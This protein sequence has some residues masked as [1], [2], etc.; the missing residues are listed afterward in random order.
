MNYNY[1]ITLRYDGGRYEGW[2][3]QQGRLTIQET[4]ENCISDVCGETVKVTASGR[5]DAGVHA[6]EQTANFHVKGKQNPEEFCRRCNEILPEDIKILSM[7]EKKSE[8]HSRF[9]ALEKTYCYTIDMREQPCVFTRRYAY[10]MPK[11]L[12]L[13]EMRKAAGCMMGEHDFRSFTSDKRKQKDTVRKLTDIR[14]ITD[15]GYLKIYFTGEGFLYHMVRILTGTLI[16]IGRGKRKAEE[17]PEIF[18]AKNRFQAGFMAPAHG[19]MLIQV[20][21]DGDKALESAGR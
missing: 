17:I 12:N 4:V 13:Q 14:M 16:E 1:K 5:T 9:D 6:M 11:Q 18:Q 20:R 7:E 21:Y 3:R 10:W 2:Q 19:L 15:K 8:F